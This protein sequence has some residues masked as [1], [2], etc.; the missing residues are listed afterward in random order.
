MVSAWL[1]REQLERKIRRLSPAIT[2]AGTE[3]HEDN[4]RSLEAAVKRA[5]SYPELA[6]A[7]GV[8]FKD[9]GVKGRRGRLSVKTIGKKGEHVLN[10]RW[11]EF[12]I[13]PHSTAKGAS[14]KRGKGQDQGRLHPGV[15][16]QPFF[17]PT[18]RAHRRVLKSRFV[19][20]MNKAAKDLAAKS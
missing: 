9:E 19:R 7:V 12:G 10:P 14:R 5:V 4:L 8:E 3:A 15:A 13:A 6:A 18:I 1:K 11:V 17:W 16:A 2:S 20:R